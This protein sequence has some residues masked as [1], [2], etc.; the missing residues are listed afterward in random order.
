MLRF[1]FS[2]F[3]SNHVA[4]RMAMV[5]GVA[6][7]LACG[8]LFIGP[9]PAHASG[10]S[11][12]GPTMFVH[13]ATS[14]NIIGDYTVLT[15]DNE[16]SYAWIYATANWNPGG[17]YHGF[18]NHPIG[19]TF[20]ESYAWTIINEDGAPMPIGA[21]FNVYIVSPMSHDPNPYVNVQINNS[22]SYISF[23][24]DPMLN[25]N[26][27]ATLMVTQDLNPGSSQY[28]PIVNPHEI[29]L[30]YDSLLGEWTIYNEDRS[31]IPLGAKFNY[32]LL[33][34]SGLFPDGFTQVATSSNTSGDSTCIDNVLSNSNPNALIFI[35]HE[36][37]GYFTDP[38]AVWYNPS[39]SEWCIFDGF[40][41][42]MP[43]GATFVVALP[44]GTL[45]S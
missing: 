44:P 38:S 16:C 34:Q 36:Y 31:P 18:D 39:L 17:V 1:H 42:N 32:M 27:S 14:T 26:P 40:Y 30:W 45:A 10:C 6:L 8:S 5:V 4:L 19:V 7:L 12:N 35:V 20:N 23:I 24:N 29:G 37:S 2:R 43:L 28:D 21:S 22:T 3:K 41:S 11:W 33:P 9:R 15:E 13:T 25:N